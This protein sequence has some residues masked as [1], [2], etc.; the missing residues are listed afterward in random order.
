M[1]LCVC[2]CSRGG[3]SLEQIVPEQAGL[4]RVLR[5]K[6]SQNCVRS[7]AALPLLPPPLLLNSTSWTS[8]SPC[9]RV[10]LEILVLAVALAEIGYTQ[11]LWGLEFSLCALPLAT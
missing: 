8:K 5:I 10:T 1:H 2:V 11:T 6:I 9:S 4:S 7:S 3:D